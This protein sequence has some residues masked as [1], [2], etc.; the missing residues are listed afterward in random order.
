MVSEVEQG[1]RERQRTNCESQREVFRSHSVGDNIQQQAY[2]RI[3]GKVKGDEKKQL[4]DRQTKRQILEDEWNNQGPKHTCCNNDEISEEKDDDPNQNTMEGSNSVR[5]VEIDLT[6]EVIDDKGI[7]EDLTV[8]ARIIGLKK[9]RLICGNLQKE[10]NKGSNSKFEFYFIFD[11]LPLY[12][13]S[14][15][16]DFNPLKFTVYETLVWIKLY[17]LP[18]EYW[19]DSCLEKIGQTLG[20]ILE[21]DEEIIE[22]D[23]Y[24]YARMKIAAAKQIP[25]LI[26]LRMANGIWK[27]GIEIEKEIYVCQRCGSKTH[28]TKTCK[29][30]VHGAYNTRQRKE[31]KE[32]AIWLKKVNEQR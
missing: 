27:R 14:W 17:N 21:I 31:D 24:I 16:P 19:G 22:N 2:D 5:R 30:F 8:I 6:E 28:Q 1:E 12:I 11:N 25:S 9:S 3:H 10:R 18:I 32:K 7:W 13:Q 26:N 23:S 4:A 29:I 15:T 20:T